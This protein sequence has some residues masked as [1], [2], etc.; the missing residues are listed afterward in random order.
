MMI[1]LIVS[2]YQ[3]C[4]GIEGVEHC[5]VIWPSHLFGLRRSC[6]VL[7]FYNP[8]LPSSDFGRVLFRI[9]LL[10][11]LVRMYHY[12]TNDIVSDITC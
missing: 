6:D 12:F 7:I 11:L 10:V 8:A 1:C 5:S 4:S 9:N 2:D 3:R